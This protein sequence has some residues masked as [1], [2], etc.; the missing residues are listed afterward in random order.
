[1]EASKST[2]PTKRSS[3]TPKGIWMKGALRTLRVGSWPFSLFLRPA[4]H[5]LGL[6]G[7]ALHMLSATTSIG[8]SSVCSPRAIIDLH[9]CMRIVKPMIAA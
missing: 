7:S 2:V 5:S 4:S 1:M 9:A 8:G 6:S 3:V